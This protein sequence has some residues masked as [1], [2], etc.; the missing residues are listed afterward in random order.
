MD[1]ER[2]AVLDREL[3]EGD[4]SS[5][6]SQLQAIVDEA[7]HVLGL[8]VA[9][10]DRHLRML[11]YTQHGESEVD[12]ARVMSIMKQPLPAEVFEWLKRHGTWSAEHPF[13][14]PPNRELELDARVAAPIRCQGHHLGAM[15]C[16]DRNQAMTD[17]DLERMA[18]FA[19]EAAV[20]LYREMLLLDLDRSRERELLRD[21][22]SPDEGLRREAAWHLAERNLFTPGGRVVALVV[23]LEEAGDDRPSEEPRIAVEAVLMRI[24][25]HLAPKHSLHLLRPDHALILAS[26]MDP[27][28]RAHGVAEFARR[29]HHELVTSVARRD[30]DPRQIVAA[31]GVAGALTDAATSYQQALRAA[32]VGATMSTFGDVV[33]WDDLGIYQMLTEIPIDVLNRDTLHSGLVKLLEAPRADDLLPTLERYLD[34]AGDVQGTAASLFLHRTTLYHRLRRIERIAD[35]DLGKGDDRLAL[36]LSVKLARLQGVTWPAPTAEGSLEPGLTD[37]G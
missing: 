7:S 8:P 26:L 11:A 21:I 14:I 33:C 1:A 5:L 34:L 10:D 31:G 37:A 29:V 24:R 27:G 12:R 20:V 18:V 30:G 19:D 3:A 9:I 16:I 15:W 4:A 36:H 25:R 23:P 6:S 32:K 35:V 2:K 17:A 13:R 28:L 22:L